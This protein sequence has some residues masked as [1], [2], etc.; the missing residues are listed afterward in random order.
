MLG[1]VSWASPSG[2]AKSRAGAKE[3]DGGGGEKK[4]SRELK[5]GAVT[6]RVIG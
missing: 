3:N 1:G 2:R 4:K 5:K 6:R